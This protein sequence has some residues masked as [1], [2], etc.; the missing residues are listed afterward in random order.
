[1]GSDAYGGIDQVLGT[2]PTIGP[3]VAEI[4]ESHAGGTGSPVKTAA[5]VADAI[6]NTLPPKSA[7][8]WKPQPCGLSREE[9]RRIVR[10][11]LG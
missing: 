3:S 4:L 7:P 8:D 9:L 6:A 10:K 2:G 5:R 11:M 1:M